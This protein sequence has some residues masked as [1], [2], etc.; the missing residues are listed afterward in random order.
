MVWSNPEQYEFLVS[1]KPDYAAAREAGRLQDW[2]PTLYTLWFERFPETEDCDTYV[3]VNGNPSQRTRLSQ[4]FNNA[5][6][7]GK[8][9]GSSSK[10]GAK[11]KVLQLLKP[12][13]R[14][15]AHE[16]YQNLYWKERN[17]GPMIEE[18]YA[19]YVAGIPKDGVKKS[20]IV[21]QNERVKELL[22]GESDEVKKLVEEARKR[23]KDGAAVDELTAQDDASALTEEEKARLKQVRLYQTAIDAL[24]TTALK[25][26]EE[27][28]Q[29]TGWAATLL[30]GGPEPNRGGDITSFSVHSTMP[31]GRDFGHGYKNFKDGVLEPY[32]RYLHGIFP[33]P[34][35]Q[36]RALPEGARM[37]SS[38]SMD[39]L[40]LNSLESMPPEDDD[41]DN[42]KDVSTKDS[43]KD[44]T[45]TGSEG[46][47][48]AAAA[49]VKK[50]KPRARRVPKAA[51]KPAALTAYE[52]LREDNSQILRDKLKAL[53]IEKASVLLG[54]PAKAKRTRAKKT[55]GAAPSRKSARRGN[56][57]TASAQYV[58]DS[59]SDGYEEE[60]GQQ[61]QILEASNTEEVQQETAQHSQDDPM[62]ISPPAN[63]TIPDASTSQDVTPSSA[64]TTSQSEGGSASDDRGK[65]DVEKPPG[66]PA[67]TGISA[68]TSSAVADTTAAKAKA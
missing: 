54:K 4:W 23:G 16:A 21:W 50:S 49:P 48:G 11:P 40:D 63:H 38:I 33:E 42:T 45:L 32:R 51:P 29:Q 6:R 18:G 2:F 67:S 57:S 28:L 5:V 35:R 25:I 66:V 61:P 1:M 47:A 44:E 65:Q 3:K 62:N 34:L 52:Q 7:P 26:V 41:D 64:L 60:E 68:A 14:W 13:R 56:N 8:G 43:S 22:K 10:A 19:A 37:G 27:I 12:K 55:T 58:E 24:P 30:I 9:E 20:R 36:K 53:E 17:L 39:G 15:A 46:P 31:D 59:S